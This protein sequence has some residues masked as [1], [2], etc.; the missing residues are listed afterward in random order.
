MATPAMVQQ[1]QEQQKQNRRYARVANALDQARDW[2]ARVTGQLVNARKSKKVVRILELESEFVQATEA[3]DKAAREYKS[4]TGVEAPLSAVP[5]PKPGSLLALRAANPEFRLIDDSVAR[6]ER[7]RD[8]LLAQIG[9]LTATLE[10]E[11]GTFSFPTVSNPFAD[12]VLASIYPDIRPNSGGVLREQ[13]I[14]R[15]S[16]EFAELTEKFRKTETER[17]EATAKRNAMIDAARR[18]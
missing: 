12:A 3:L 16:L 4:T 10:K 7:E 2:L 14:A 11:R 15:I 17:L 8:R 13:N 9:P 5:Q 1:E 6:L 18:K